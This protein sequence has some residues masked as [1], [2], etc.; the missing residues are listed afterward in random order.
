MNTKKTLAFL[1]K[2]YVIYKGRPSA[3]FFLSAYKSGYAGMR[4]TIIRRFNN[5]TFINSQL[6]SRDS[7][8]YFFFI[9]LYDNYIKI[10]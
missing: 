5:N 8:N 1:Y 7:K 9:K 4:L 6:R 10:C 2:I 3:F